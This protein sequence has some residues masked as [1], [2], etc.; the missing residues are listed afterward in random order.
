VSIV[1]RFLDPLLVKLARRMEHLSIHAPSDYREEFTRS[2][3]RFSQHAIVTS[4]ARV[5][6]VAPADHIEVGDYSYI[7]G[8]ILLLTPESRLRM[9]KY[10]FLG[11]ESRVWALG[12]I[13]IGDFV[14]IAPRVDIFDNDS[15]P[16]ESVKRRED[17]MDLFERK[18]PMDYSNVAQAAIVIDDDVWIG[19]KSTIMKGVHI[20]RGA[21]IAA[22]SVVT[23]DVPPFTLVAGNPAREIRTLDGRDP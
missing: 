1:W 7:E 11:S 22:A 14:L 2:L 3:G 12:T 23:K 10:S 15:H 18:R 4:R 21:V 8:D 17:A 5:Q 20:G 16:V 19:T 6:S 13:A 9:G